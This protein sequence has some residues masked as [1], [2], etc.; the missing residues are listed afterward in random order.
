[1]SSVQHFFTF[2]RFNNLGH[3]LL[4]NS[5]V[6]EVYIKSSLS[7]VDFTLPFKLQDHDDVC[8]NFA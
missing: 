3:V 2:T 7:C 6:H 1:M 5:C 8:V 4:R